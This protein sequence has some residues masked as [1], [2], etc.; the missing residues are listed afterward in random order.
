MAAS[1]WPSVS[2]IRRLFVIY[3]VAALAGGFLTFIVLTLIYTPRVGLLFLAGII[4]GAL[5]G[6]AAKAGLVVRAWT[7]ALDAIR[8]PRAILPY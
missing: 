5:A 4:I 8:H 6:Y 7:R 3:S 2:Y 1:T